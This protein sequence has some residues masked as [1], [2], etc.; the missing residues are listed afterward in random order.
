MASSNAN[1][2]VAPPRLSASART[3]PDWLLIAIVMGAVL[4]ISVG[5]VMA[6]VKSEQSEAY[7]AGTAPGDVVHNYF[8]AVNHGDTKRAYEYLSVASR[9]KISYERFAQMAS[10]WAPA[11]APRPRLRIDSVQ[12][13]DE[14]ATVSVTIRRTVRPGPFGIVGSDE[15]S[16]QSHI[17]LRREGEQWRIAVP[18]G[19]PYQYLPYETLFGY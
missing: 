11:D 8:L 12:I 19:E 14:T 18:T 17:V 1:V 4:L 16:Y 10:N 2:E 7:V 6:F 9:D 13:D 5:L 15:L 3:G